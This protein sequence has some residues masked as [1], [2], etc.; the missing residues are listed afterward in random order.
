MDEPG[1]VELETVGDLVSSW[2]AD[3]GLPNFLKEKRPD[4]ICVKSS[5]ELAGLVRRAR[6]IVLS[7]DG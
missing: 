7:A 5:T 2:R 6:R 1:T 4:Q 3:L